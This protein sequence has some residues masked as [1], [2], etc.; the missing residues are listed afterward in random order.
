[1]HTPLDMTHPQNK[2]QSTGSTRKRLASLFGMHIFSLK[3]YKMNKSTC[4]GMTCQYLPLPVTE[5][6]EK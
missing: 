1:M 6:C 2:N 3:I 4:Y 5:V